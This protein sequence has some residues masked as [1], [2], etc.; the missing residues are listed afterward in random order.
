LEGKESSLTTYHYLMI[1]GTYLIT[2]LGLF[3]AVGVFNFVGRAYLGLDQKNAEPLDP[4]FTS[5]H[6]VR[7]FWWKKCELRDVM[8]TFAVIEVSSHFSSSSEFG[9]KP[10]QALQ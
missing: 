4:L 2:I 6:F 1:L 7:D 9:C 8:P 3:D 5:Q 10:D